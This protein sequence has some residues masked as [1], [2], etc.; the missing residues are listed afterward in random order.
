LSKRVCFAEA[1][2]S[3]GVFL[4]GSLA[5]IDQRAAQTPSPPPPELPSTALGLGGGGSARRA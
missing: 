4:F 3:V 2:L 5:I 1:V